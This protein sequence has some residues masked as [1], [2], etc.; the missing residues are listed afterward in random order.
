[1]KILIVKYIANF[2]TLTPDSK[3]GKKKKQ[4]KHKKHVS[5]CKSYPAKEGYAIKNLL[6]HLL[7]LVCSFL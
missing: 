4:K 7:S 2:S 3:W 5:E 1:M 6:S